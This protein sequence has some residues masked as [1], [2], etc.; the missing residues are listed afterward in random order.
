MLASVSELSS[1]LPLLASAGPST[2]DTEMNDPSS[3]VRRQDTMTTD[4][5]YSHYSI[6]LTLSQWI[7]TDKDNIFNRV[8][9]DGGLFNT[10]V[11]IDV[12][13]D[14]SGQFSD[15]SFHTSGHKLL[16][17]GFP[18]DGM[19]HSI[20]LLHHNS[21]LFQQTNINV[22]PSRSSL[23]VV[24]R[25]K[26]SNALPA[27]WFLKL[28]GEVDEPIIL[29]TLNMAQNTIK[30]QTLG[31]DT[32]VASLFSQRFPVQ[33][34]MSEESFRFDVT[35]SLFGVTDA[36][37]SAEA[38]ADESEQALLRVS[39]SLERGEIWQGIEDRTIEHLDAVP[40]GLVSRRDFA[41]ESTEEARKMKER[42]VPQ[43]NKA[44]DE[45][46]NASQLYSELRRARQRAEL[47]YH[48]HVVR[49]TLD[50]QFYE[51]TEL[52][53][54]LA[55]LCTLEDSCVK[56]IASRVV[57]QECDLQVQTNRR[58]FGETTCRRKRTFPEEV[59]QLVWGPLVT[60]M[61]GPEVNTISCDSSI[62]SYWDYPDFGCTIIAVPERRRD[63]SSPT[64]HRVNHT[65]FVEREVEYTCNSAWD[66]ERQWVMDHYCCE[67]QESSFLHNHTC[68]GRNVACRLAR[69]QAFEVFGESTPPDAT[70][71][72]S[73]QDILL[74]QLTLAQLKESEALESYQAASRAH[75]QLSYFKEQIEHLV[76]HREEQATRLEGMVQLRDMNSSYNMSIDEITFNL[77]V[78]S[79]LSTTI[80]LNILFSLPNSSNNTMMFDFHFSS[81][82]SS[83]AA[84]THTLYQSI[85][86]SNDSAEIYAVGSTDFNKYCQDL[87]QLTS[88]VRQLGSSLERSAEHFNSSMVGVEGLTSD[89]SD[90]L[91]SVRE[92][93]NSGAWLMPVEMM[94]ET[95]MCN[96]SAMPC[97][98]TSNATEEVSYEAEVTHFEDLV[99]AIIVASE[100]I[101]Y[102]AEERAYTR[103]FLDMEEE[104]GRIMAPY[105]CQGL[106]DCVMTAV[107]VLE[108]ILEVAG[109]AAEG[110]E[111][112]GDIPAAKADLIALV[113]S[114][115]A[116]VGEMHKLLKKVETLLQSSLDFDYWC[117]LTPD[118]SV[119]GS[120]ESPVRNGT[121][122][123]YNC[124]STSKFPTLFQWLKDGSALPGE[125]R[126]T[127]ALPNVTVE[128]AGEYTCVSWTH[129]G[130]E[131]ETT[132][133]LVVHQYPELTMQPMNDVTVF[134]EG[135]AVF[136]RCNASGV[137]APSWQWYFRSPN[138]NET[139][140]L[141]NETSS[142]L[143]IL[144][145]SPSREGWY[146]C[147]A[148]NVDDCDNCSVRSDG[149]YLR[150]LESSVARIAVPYIIE[151]IE[152][153]P[154]SNDSS[155]T[156]ESRT[157]DYVSFSEEEE[158]D[159]LSQN[160][161]ELVSSV[162]DLGS[163]VLSE[164]TVAS[165]LVDINSTIH[166][167]SFV[168][169]SGSLVPDEDNKPEK[170][171]AEIETLRME[172]LDG[173][174]SVA[175]ILPNTSVVDY[176]DLGIN[177]DE[178][179]SAEVDQS[180]LLVRC[181]EGQE[182][183]RDTNLFCGECGVGSRG[184]EE[185]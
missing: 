107:E 81:I 150:V 19:R 163:V 38:M 173:I 108:R 101:V 89:L 55:G 10:P 77:F 58:V 23:A 32:A 3:R 85:L 31:P 57:C 138:S 92:W 97:N 79:R 72:F 21:S 141:E 46:M 152:L 177:Y 6:S 75:G 127:L 113:L 4:L 71:L 56:E 39:G 74:Q 15:V 154:E 33:L 161:T 82:E 12:T 67:V 180:R 54:Y 140:P 84:A 52:Y 53:Q 115:D 73:R 44:F 11:T 37:V 119:V 168:I 98:N 86:N 136:F 18:F 5:P 167:L 159:G 63:V 70:E 25:P 69:S 28:N 49:V 155:P 164:A 112:L 34:H 45:M 178:V 24:S 183:R 144:P 88:F 1:H 40:E 29:T 64:L 60:H 90:R 131:L 13:L 148:S 124:S 17:G 121:S 62:P 137:P 181:P 128:S 78:E 126:P 36:K 30:G 111:L 109:G 14:S 65:T 96:D 122:M 94:N 184:T 166:T 114:R 50:T 123:E 133:R 68:L 105:G 125:T 132:T 47:Q 146:Y 51:D 175:P 130:E 110:V 83:I 116:G 2:V 7:V 129:K 174:K 160:L 76:R 93:H 143:I 102:S 35:A 170:T 100:E 185:V 66:Q 20:Y 26:A 139:M 8:F 135:G 48:S 118:L 61:E 145:P 95:T 176:G 182:L 149:V 171:F 42:I 103:W 165:N 169:S 153:W 172:W 134:P 27:F 162:L 142:E 22:V 158:T 99:M 41:Q 87:Q 156:V 9:S 43:L 179:R 120:H 91:Y 117:E 106:V 59:S 104:V 157:A 151:F 16:S 80:P 147:E